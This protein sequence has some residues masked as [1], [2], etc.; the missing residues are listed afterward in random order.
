MSLAS[1]IIGSS[2]TS[3]GDYTFDWCRRLTSV[4]IPDGVTSIGGAAFW[5]CT[6]L[7]SITIPSSVISIGSSAF[8]ECNSLARVNYKGTEEQWNK[9]QIGYWND[10]LTSAKRNYI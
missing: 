9:I 1:I 7:T 10:D 3:I 2:V 5:Y 4:T 8:G 6:S